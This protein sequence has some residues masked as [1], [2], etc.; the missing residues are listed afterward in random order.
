MIKIGNYTIE[1]QVYQSSDRVSYNFACD[2]SYQRNVESGFATASSVEFDFGENTV[3]LYAP[4]LEVE[5]IR[6]EELTVI[7]TAAPLPEDKTAE[8]E[9]KI[10]SLE[11]Q[12]ADATE[13]IEA[14]GEAIV[15]LAEMISELLDGKGE[16][17]G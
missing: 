12:L 1:T 17:N 3:I 6:G 11:E 13:T 16:V 14:D 15:E 9:A 8:Y 5:Q 7:F 10:S 2:K 4:K